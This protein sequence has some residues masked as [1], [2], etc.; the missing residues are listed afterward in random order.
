MKKWVWIMAVAAWS[1]GMVQAADRQVD[2]AAEKATQN[3]VKQIEAKLQKKG[4]DVGNIAF[5]PLFNDQAGIYPVVRA[6][7]TGLDSGLTFFMREPEDW[8]KLVKEIEFA[9]KRGDIMNKSTIQRFG[10][11][12]GV[13]ALLYGEV[14]EAGAKDED[15]S[16]VRLTLVLADVETGEQI[17][18][19]N[20]SGIVQEEEEPI[21]ETLLEKLK[22]NWKVI[23][24]GIGVVVVL[25]VFISKNSRPR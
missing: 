9:Q 15:S 19:A 14:R 10:S 22:E 25:L 12:E 1:V 18:S 23:G 3:A 13:D 24:I 11:I 17:A 7:L 21:S 2:Y 6:E 20:V 5:L 4:V 16:I 8:K